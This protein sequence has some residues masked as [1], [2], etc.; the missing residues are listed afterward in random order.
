MGVFLKCLVM[1]NWSESVRGLKNGIRDGKVSRNF[2]D[3]VI[4]FSLILTKCFFL[5]LPMCHL[6]FLL[7]LLSV[8][9]ENNFI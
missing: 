4:V 7:T 3:Q 2:F 6:T 8:N 5:F 1:K 9:N